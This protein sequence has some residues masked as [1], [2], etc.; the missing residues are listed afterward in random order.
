MPAHHEEPGGEKHRASREDGSR[1]VIPLA[2]NEVRT[3]RHP[4]EPEE[5]RDEERHAEV[6][7][8]P[9]AGDT[10]R[11][12]TRKTYPAWL[13]CGAKQVAEGFTAAA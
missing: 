8:E 5:S 1:D 13:G 3:D 4:G 12:S 7:P 9:S 2:V 10:A 6:Q 11:H